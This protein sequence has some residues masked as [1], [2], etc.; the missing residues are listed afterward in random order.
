[1]GRDPATLDIDEI[2]TA[3]F[4]MGEWRRRLVR[5]RARAVDDLD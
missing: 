3:D 5:E 1:L 2:L 4:A